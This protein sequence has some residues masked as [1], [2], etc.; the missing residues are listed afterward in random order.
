M[1]GGESIK[2]TD[3]LSSSEFQ[4]LIDGVYNTDEGFSGR[5]GFHYCVFADEIWNGRSGVNWGLEY[6]VADGHSYVN[7][8]IKAQAGLLMHETGHSI[9]LLPGKES[10]GPG[11]FPGI[12]NDN[13]QNPGDSEYEKYAN[14]KSCMN[15]RYTKT[16]I[17]Y[18]NGSHGTNDHDDWGDIN[19]AK[20]L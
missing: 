10:Q 1:G 9:G 18:S 20:Y 14:Y 7:H 16:I 8:K 15:Y 6:I 12:D 11:Y 2:H 5:T 13:S 17:D 3:T 4:E 19:L